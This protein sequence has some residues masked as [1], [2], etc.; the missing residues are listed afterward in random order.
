MRLWSVIV[1]GHSIRLYSPH[2]V[3]AELESSQFSFSCFDHKCMDQMIW[4]PT[5][6]G[7]A[8]VWA[9]AASVALH[10]T[11]FRKSSLKLFSHTRI[12]TI[13]SRSAL[14]AIAPLHSWDERSRSAN[15]LRSRS[16]PALHCSR[17]TPAP[18]PLLHLWRLLR[19]RGKPIKL[20]FWRLY[21]SLRTSHR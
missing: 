10:I 19:L 8:H 14:A 5:Q 2:Q 15:C 1:G 16:P 20:V 11:S 3:C 21:Q 12:L 18:T 4:P 13:S 6:P 7:G 9:Q 17:T